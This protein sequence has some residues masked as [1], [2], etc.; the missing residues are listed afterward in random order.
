[1]GCLYQLTSPS[2]K[3]YIGI[4]KKTA[5]LRFAKHVEHALGKREN[6]V[7]Y[8]AL[9]KYQP[10]NF[11]IETL[12]MANDWLYLNELEAKVIAAFG[13]RHPAGYNMTD[14]GGG[15]QGPISEKARENISRA[16]KLRYQR[17]EELE[18]IRNIQKKATAS[19]VAKHASRRVNGKA[20]WE[21]RKEQS[22]PRRGSIEHRTNQSVAMKE[23]MGRPEVAAKVKACAL[24]RS[25]DP[26]WRIKIGNSKRGKSIGPCTPERKAKIAEVRRQEWADPIMRQKRIDANRAARKPHVQINCLGC[27]TIFF[28][29]QWQA[30]Q[31]FCSHPCFLK[32]RSEFK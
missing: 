4:T 26:Q 12:V 1:M 23:A 18:R 19:T 21:I 13:T 9:R 11:K 20:P 6:G 15:T 16:Q 14:G 3:A 30:H 5:S 32:H 22:R 2:G 31:K 29:P 28:K 7:L 10:E 24:V 25:A 17:P 27:A 8:S